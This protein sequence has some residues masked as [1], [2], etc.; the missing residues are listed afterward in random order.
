VIHYP[1][2]W[3][4][5]ETLH[6]IG[7]ALLVGIVGTIDL[8]MLGMAKNMP[9][10]PLHRLL[11]WAIAG[12]GINLITGILFFAG[13]PFQYIHNLASAEAAFHF[14]CWTKRTGVLS[15]HIQA[16]PGPGT[17]RG[18]GA[19]S[20]SRR[21]DF[22]TFS[23]SFSLPTAV[24][25]DKVAAEYKDGGLKIVLPKKEEIKPKPI[26]VEAG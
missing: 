16:D 12:F 22:G 5:S 18:R 11:P 23:R 9:F 14:A 3:P 8:R 10:R 21:G 20:Q 19:A 7:L 2:V 13:D 24:N 17:R 1:W 25:G 6:F 4:A 26:K 15:D